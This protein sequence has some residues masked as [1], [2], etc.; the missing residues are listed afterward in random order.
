M[1]IRGG[2]NIYPVEIENLL[3][4]HAAI[5]ECAVFG[6]PDH[7]Y[8]EIVAAAL[9]LNEDISTAAIAAFLGERIARFKIPAVIYRVERFPLTAS[10]KIRKVELRAMAAQGALE[11]LS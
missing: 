2:E 10:G 1:I 5:A 11:K 7:F 8:G 3:A 9:R 4:I 6:V